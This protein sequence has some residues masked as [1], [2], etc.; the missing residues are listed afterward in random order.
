MTIEQWDIA[1]AGGAL[2]TPP[3]IE[4]QLAELQP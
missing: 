2:A 1:L 4:A 3:R